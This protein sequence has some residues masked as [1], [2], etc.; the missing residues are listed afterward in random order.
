[1]GYEKTHQVEGKGQFSVRGGIIDIFDLTGENPCRIEL[2]GDEVE[3]I[4]SFDILSQRSIEQLDEITIFPGTE[5]ML[6][7]AVLTSL[8]ISAG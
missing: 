4:R 6:S 3:S 1:M 2:W 8:T 7:A 5:L